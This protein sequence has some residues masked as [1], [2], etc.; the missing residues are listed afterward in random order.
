MKNINWKKES[1]IWIALLTPFIYSFIIWNKIPDQVPTH[2]NVKGEVDDYSGKTF[3]M[4]LLPGMNVLMYFILFFIPRID[5]RYQHYKMFGPSYQNIRLIIHIF[6]VGIF[7]FTIHAALTNNASGFNFFMAG[8]G[9]FFAL[10]GNYMRTVRSNWFVGFRTPWTLSNE[11]VWKKTHMLGGRI[12]F[13]GGLI[14]AVTC[15]FL[16]QVAAGIVLACGVG[17]M[18]FVPIVYSYFK[19]RELVKPVSQAKE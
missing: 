14:L 19:Y 15:L 18:A 10:M 16:S 12:W 17:V 6:F 5:P 9:L 7:A 2:W 8:M 3:A 13:Y 11:E 4:F 1:L